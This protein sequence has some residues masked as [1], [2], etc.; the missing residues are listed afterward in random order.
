MAVEKKYSCILNYGGGVG[1]TA[2][3]VALAKGY[4]PDIQLKETLVVFADT[5]A[6]RPWTY[7]YLKHFK[8][9]CKKNGLA[10][11]IVRQKYTLEEYVFH[12]GILPSR[13]IR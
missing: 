9:F 10:F 8:M 11:E 7:E 5:G 13:R 2:L 12:S 4:V 6:E 3:A 1:S